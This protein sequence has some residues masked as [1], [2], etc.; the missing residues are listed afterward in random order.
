MCLPKDSVLR[1]GFADELFQPRDID[2]NAARRWQDIATE[3]LWLATT[4]NRQS[5]R[6][7]YASNNSSNRHL[8][9]AQL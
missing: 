8:S 4:K 2:V 5:R 6:L 7:C 9:D 3:D 1:A